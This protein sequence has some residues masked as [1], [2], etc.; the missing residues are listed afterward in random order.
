MHSR[1]VPFFFKV[2]F[3]RL[4]ILDVFVVSDHVLLRLLVELVCISFTVLKQ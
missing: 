4:S 1:G 2:G 3:A